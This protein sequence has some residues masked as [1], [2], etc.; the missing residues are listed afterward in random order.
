MTKKS[1]L[2]AIPL[3]LFIWGYFPSTISSQEANRCFIS[4]DRSSAPNLFFNELTFSI[5]TNDAADVS[6]TTDESEVT[7]IADQTNQAVLLS[8]SAETITVNLIPG[9]ELKDLCKTTISPLKDGKKW[10]WSHGFDDNVNLKPSIEAFVEKGWPATLFP[11]TKDYSSSRNQDW[12]IDEP[13]F[14]RTL[15]NQGWA[16]GNHSWNHERFDSASPSFEDYVA[17]ILDAQTKLEKSIARS[18]TPG[19]QVMAFAAPNFSSAYERPFEVAAESSNLQFLESG[20]IFLHELNSDID[21][22][23]GDFVA[24]SLKGQSKIGRDPSIEYDPQFAIR[25]FNWMSENSDSQ[26]WF[27]YNT[28]S[29]GGHEAN[30]QQVL[31]Y[32]WDS[33]GP[34]GTD[35][36]WVASSTEIYSYQLLRNHVLID[37]TFIGEDLQAAQLEN[38]PE[39]FV[40]SYM[41]WA[42][43]GHANQTDSSSHPLFLNLTGLGLQNFKSGP[44]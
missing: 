10:A 17:D 18:N 33:Y 27:W 4:I 26:R 22:R 25:T 29:H 43:L 15:I 5:Q 2:I 14:N 28:L 30:I 23:K 21:F 6:V 38:H 42:Q 9:K 32:A 13:Y 44:E 37:V 34:A 16:L 41:R 19:F 36:A 39:L 40:D 20:S 12:I 24:Y 8:T 11:I 3:L 31:D 7:L 35:E 1:I